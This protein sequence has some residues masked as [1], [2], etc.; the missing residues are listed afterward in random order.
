MAYR[1][2]VDTLL[3]HRAASGG[4]P[5]S[6]SAGYFTTGIRHTGKDRQTRLAASATQRMRSTGSSLWMLQSEPRI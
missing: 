4:G 5:V 1:Y 6:V 2:V 3:F